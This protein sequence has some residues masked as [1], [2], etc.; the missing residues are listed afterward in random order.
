[1]ADSPKDAMLA[2]QPRRR[3]QGHKELRPIRVRTSIC[4]RQDPR[5]FRTQEV[6]SYVMTATTDQRAIATRE[7]KGEQ[8]PKRCKILYKKAQKRRESSGKVTCMAQ[9]TRKFVR[10][11][12]PKDALASS[13]RASGVAA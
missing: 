13:T 6:T 12:S 2:V 9:I 3:R 7:Q 5:P 11:L 10:K 8:T 1:M 4:H